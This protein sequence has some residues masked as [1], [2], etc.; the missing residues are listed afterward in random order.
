MHDLSS[1]DG[2]QNCD[3]QEAR[4]LYDEFM[5][6]RKSVDDVSAAE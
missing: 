5:N 6:K 2:R 1:E 4:S 3:L